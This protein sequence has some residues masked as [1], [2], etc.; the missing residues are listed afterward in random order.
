MLWNEIAKICL[1]ILSSSI[2]LIYSDT[3]AVA[4][5]LESNLKNM[6]NEKQADNNTIAMNYLSLAENIKKLL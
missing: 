6:I 2:S 5:N 1:D 4:I 3:R